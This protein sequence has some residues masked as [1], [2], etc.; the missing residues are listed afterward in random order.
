MPVGAAVG[1][2]AAPTRAI[3]DM[4]PLIPADLLRALGLILSLIHI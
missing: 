4:L 1:R 2:D 3:A